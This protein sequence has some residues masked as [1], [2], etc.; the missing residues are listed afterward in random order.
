MH[1]DE[2]LL[3]LLPAPVLKHV[4]IRYEDKKFNGSFM[5]VDVFRQRGSPEVDAAW[6]SLGVNCE[7]LSGLA[8]RTF[9]DGC[10]G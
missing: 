5:D 6:E 3:T 1:P 7:L 8:P 2:H 10:E 9:C 4:K